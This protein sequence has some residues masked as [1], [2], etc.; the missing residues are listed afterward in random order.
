M[1]RDSRTGRDTAVIRGTYVVR[2]GDCLWR[3]AAGHLGVGANETTIAKE[4]TRLWKLNAKRI[5]TGNPD[6]IY[7]GQKL[8]L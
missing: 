6:L 1:R 7:P 8:E 3:V 2:E 4:V 5:G